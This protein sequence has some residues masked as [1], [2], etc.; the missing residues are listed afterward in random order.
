MHERADNQAD[1]FVEEAVAVEIDRYARP[2]VA[3]A[4]RINCANGA[5]FPFAT[6]CSKSCE[7]MSADEAFGCCPKNFEIKRARNM[8]G[9]PILEWGQHR[10]R[11]DSVAIDFS[12]CGK[13]R[14]KTFRN[15]SAAKHPNHRRQ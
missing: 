4:Q 6:I 5:P 15:I 13:A 14:V 2:V 8:P 7:I 10:S 1:R 12:F 9:S 3:D 11:P